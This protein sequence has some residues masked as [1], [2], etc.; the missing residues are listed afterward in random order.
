MMRYLGIIQ[1]VE[2]ITKYFI[3]NVQQERDENQPPGSATLTSTVEV[4][5]ERLRIMQVVEVRVVEVV[6]V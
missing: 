1:E 5:T 4:F 2:N 6:L 3:T